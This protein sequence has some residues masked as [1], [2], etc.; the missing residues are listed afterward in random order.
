MSDPIGSPVRS[1][2]ESIVRRA[3]VAVGFILTCATFA[4]AQQPLPDPPATPQFMSRFDFHLA[5]AGLRSDDERF[6]F[7]T[8]WGGDFD[9]FDYVYGRA[10]IVADYQALLGS[11]FRPFDP[12][13]SNYLL[14]AASSARIG[15]TEI[16]GVLSHVSR[17][18]GDRP[19]RIAVAENSVGPRVLRQFSLGTTTVDTR[20]DLR[21]VI[22]EAFNDYEW[23][24]DV[25]VTARRPV[26][27]HVSLYVRVFGETYVVDRAIAGRGRQDGGRFESGVRLQGSGGAMDL[28][29]GYEKVVDAAPLDRTAQ[30]WAFAG[31]RL[32]GK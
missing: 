10:T 20:A 9:L 31:F 15:K 7:D 30:Q 32:V 14:E 16:Y 11:E 8:H 4:L 23:L 17:H 1:P 29:L 6:S 13:Q 19:K 2:V 12:Y 5:A 28:F 27:G 3:A 26:N 18:L 25:D 22:A 24:A 21:K